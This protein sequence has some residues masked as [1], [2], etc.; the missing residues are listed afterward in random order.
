M[1]S[2]ILERFSHKFLADFQ[3]EHSVQL[4]AN[5][6]IRNEWAEDGYKTAQVS[7]HELEVTGFRW[8]HPSGAII[9]GNFAQPFVAFERV[10]NTY[11][12]QLEVTYHDERI[13]D[14]IVAKCGRISGFAECH[15]A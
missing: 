10:S 14:A 9:S 7:H 2:S 11:G 8:E 4:I 6:D 12:E 5:D 13:C 3:S 15:L 1:N